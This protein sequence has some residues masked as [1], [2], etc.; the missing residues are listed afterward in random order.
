MCVSVSSIFIYIFLYEL[1]RIHPLYS[2]YV[3]LIWCVICIS[4]ITWK[5]YPGRSP[6][7]PEPTWHVPPIRSQVISNSRLGVLTIQRTPRNTAPLQ[8]NLPD[9]LGHAHK[10]QAVTMI[11][12]NLNLLRSLKERSTLYYVILQTWVQ[13]Y[14]DDNTTR[15]HNSSVSTQWKPII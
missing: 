9:I 2:L 11:A 7:S 1:Y 12:I 8:N 13:S 3:E 14:F 4:C 5:G 6:G 10:K 15:V